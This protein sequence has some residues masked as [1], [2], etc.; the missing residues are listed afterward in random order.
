MN[1]CV[2]VRSKNKANEQ[3]HG[4]KDRD[5]CKSVLAGHVRN[6]VDEQS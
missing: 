6:T 2:A 4:E 1:V 5:I 3:N